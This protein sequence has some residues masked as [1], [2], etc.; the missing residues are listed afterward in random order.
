MAADW[1]TAAAGYSAELMQRA[2][3]AAPASLGDVWM[4]NWRATGL[5]TFTGSGQP[6]ED[7]FNDMIDKASAQIGPIPQAARD[8]GLDW[9]GARGFDAKAAIVA[10]LAGGLPKDAQ[11][12]LAPVLDFRARAAEKAAALERDASDVNGRTYGLSGATTAWLAGTARQMLDPGNLALMAAGGGEGGLLLTAAK[13]AGLAAAGQAVQEPVIQDNRAELGLD[14][15]LGRAVSDVANVG[16]GTFGT[17][18]GLPLLF[19]GAGFVARKA[20]GLR[21]PE[22]S[23]DAPAAPAPPEAPLLALPHPDQFAE[24]IIPP[25]FNAPKLLAPPAIDPSVFVTGRDLMNSLALRAASGDAERMAERLATGSPIDM[26]DI[27]LTSEEAALQERD[28]FLANNLMPVPDDAAAAADRLA[29]VREIEGQLSA[30]TGDRRA[31][32]ARRDELLT[33]TTPEA[34]AQQ[35]AALEQQRVIGAERASIADRLNAI[36]VE[37]LR[38][39]AERVDAVPGTRSMVHIDPGAAMADMVHLVAPN[40]FDAAALHAERDVIVPPHPAIDDAAARAERGDALPPREMPPGVSPLQPRPEPAE[41]RISDLPFPAEEK[42]AAPAPAQPV[43]RDVGSDQETQA[44]APPGNPQLAADAERA[45]AATGGDF[46]LALEDETTG[47]V[48]RGS[49]RQMMQEA[50]ENAAAARELVECLGGLGAGET[51]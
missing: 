33:D 8:A 50:A 3:A 23:A 29:R 15:G 26:R 24:T 10:Q 34:L 37:R 42:R 4:A 11:E 25:N 28:Q 12:Q 32:F 43:K 31:L 14:S 47:E 39:S 38:I 48:R 36:G 6:T 40:D 7:A 22:I 17:A 20:L 2:G 41:P 35:A 13:T 5:D 49:A 44:A 18:V 16:V 21:A 45:L 30:G 46:H 51:L 9:A 19:R 1:D 27:H